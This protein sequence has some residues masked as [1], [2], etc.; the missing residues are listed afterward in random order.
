M[1]RLATSI[2][3]SFND[4]GSGGNNKVLKLEQETSVRPPYGTAYARLFTSAEV[5]P[6]LKTTGQ[7]PV[8][9]ENPWVT[10]QHNEVLVFNGSIETSLQYPSVSFVQFVA[11]GVFLDVNGKEIQKLSLSVNT[12]AGSIRAS[13]A[14]YGYVLV[15]YTTTYSRISAK[16]T[17]IE[18]FGLVTAD[19]DSEFNS[20]MFL[21]FHEQAA[22]S[23]T[24]S[25]PPKNQN[26]VFYN[27]REDSSA[28]RLILELDP[29]FPV[30]LVPGGTGVMARA[31]FFVYPGDAMPTF[32]V[33]SGTGPTRADFMA[34]PGVTVGEQT[35]QMSEPLSF[36]NSQSVNVKYP[37]KSMIVVDPSGPFRDQFGY[38]FT[39]MFVAGGGSVNAVDWTENG[40]YTIL[41]T[42]A[43]RSNEIFAC[44]SGSIVA[45]CSGVAIAKYATTRMRYVLEWP[46]LNDWFPAVTVFADSSNGMSG[47]LKIEPPVRR[48]L[49]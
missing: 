17:K 34:L 16:F 25:P 13:Q 24:I 6:T 11:Q 41:G 36:N 9:V 35:I 5:T 46:K 12:K 7:G 43:V 39:P 42:K 32:Q 3:V 31:V 49:L 4:G 18:T 33:T 44:I 19:Q 20:L 22:S 38:T 45:P 14:C 37:P 23:V 1:S 29:Q 40:K 26:R 21:A 47:E 27:L 30:T 2:S 28:P 10:N 15:S 8:Q 48:G